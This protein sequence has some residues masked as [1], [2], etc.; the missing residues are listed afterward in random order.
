MAPC[1]T[2]KDHRKII[3]HPIWAHHVEE[4][5]HLRHQSDMKQIYA[6]RKETI[7]RVFTLR[8]KSMVCVGQP[9]EGLKN[10][11]CRRCILLLPCN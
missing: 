7:E 2:S 5:D 10:C 9:Y 6:R 4:A 3:E 1:T 11:P 8:K